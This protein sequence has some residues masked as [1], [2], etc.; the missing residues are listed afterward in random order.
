MEGADRLGNERNEGDLELRTS[1]SKV[2][3]INAVPQSI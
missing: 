1:S 3:S 2:W